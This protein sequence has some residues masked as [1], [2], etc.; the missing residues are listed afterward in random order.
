MPRKKSPSNP[1]RCIL[2][3]PLLRHHRSSRK[4]TRSF[5][6]RFR[7]KKK[8]AGLSCLKLSRIKQQTLYRWI[9]L[10]PPAFKVKIAELGV[11]YEDKIKAL[12]GKHQ[13][14]VE[15]EKEVEKEKEKQQLKKYVK[16]L[17]FPS[18][19]LYLSRL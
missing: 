19:T 18:L 9:S 14:E 4:T 15:A 11:Q 12:K 17:S 10:P 13:R 6:P 2:S 7:R 5:R 8:D 3:L 1:Y 16:C